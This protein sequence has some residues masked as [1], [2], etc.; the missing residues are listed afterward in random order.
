ML[1][2]LSRFL[3]FWLVAAALVA[4]VV[5]GAKSIAASA[6]VITPLAETLCHDL[7]GRRRPAQS[8][9]GPL[10]RA[11]LGLAARRAHGRRARGARLS[12]PG[13]GAKRRAP[14]AQPR[15]RNLRIAA[16]AFHVPVRHA[17]QKIAMP[18]PEDAL[19][20]RPEPIPTAETHFVNGRKLKG[21]YPEGMEKA[22]FGLGCF[23]GA[24]RVFWKTPGVYVTAVGYA[25]GYTPNPTYQEVCTGRT[26]HNEVVLVVFD[27]KASPM[28]EL[29]QRL[30]GGA[31]PDAGHAAGQRRRHAVPLRH[32]RLQ[33]RAAAA[34]GGLAR[35]VPAGAKA[36]RAARSPRRSSRRRPS[37][38]PRTITSNIW[39]RTRPAIAG[40]AAPA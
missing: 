29:L 31:R 12:L 8:A 17:R 30:L 38:S 32:L 27:P 21:P 20:G 4:G 18:G 37:T 16:E 23:W 22:L 7:G 36:K 39:R 19:A 40:S 13:G 2:F 34:G 3:G 9:A 1:R 6:L 11:C 35:H 5:D 24:E 28:R 26:G 25:G 14:F 33:R 15:I 10:D